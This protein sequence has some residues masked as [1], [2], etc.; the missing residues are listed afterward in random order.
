VLFELLD[1]ESHGRLRHEQ[2]FGRLGE[3]QLLGNR[4]KNL[5]PAISHNPH[6]E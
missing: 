3:R 5:K 1:L 2:H 6:P 4:V